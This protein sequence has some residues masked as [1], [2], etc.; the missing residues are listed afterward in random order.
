[1]DY[2][3]TINEEWETTLPQEWIDK[4]DVS[5]VTIQEDINWSLIITPAK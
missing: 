3:L 1:M 2:I 5:K 4:Y